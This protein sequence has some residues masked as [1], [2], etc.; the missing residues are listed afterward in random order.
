MFNLALKPSFCK[1]PVTT[2]AF[3]SAVVC[4]FCFAYS[5]LPFC[6][7][8]G[9]FLKFLFLFGWLCKLFDKALVCAFACAAL[10]MCLQ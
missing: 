5:H 7:A 9:H 2:S 6:R 10:A 1:T 3:L 8:V 4:M